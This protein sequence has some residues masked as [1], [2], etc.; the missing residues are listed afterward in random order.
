MDKS[1]NHTSPGLVERIQRTAVS[2]AEGDLLLPVLLASQISVAFVLQ[3]WEAS[4]ALY[5]Y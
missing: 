4:A 2:L 1:P 5:S 3:V